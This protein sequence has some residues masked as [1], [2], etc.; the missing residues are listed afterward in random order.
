MEIRPETKSIP[1]GIKYYRVMIQ[2][3]SVGYGSETIRMW[4]HP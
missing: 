4:Y 3:S 1:I 2:I